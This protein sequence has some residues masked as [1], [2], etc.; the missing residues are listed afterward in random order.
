MKKDISNVVLLDGDVLRQIFGNDADHTIN[1]REK[2]ARR[3][4]NLSKF[5]SNE[6][7]HVVAAVSIFPEWQSGIVITFQDTARY[8]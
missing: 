6:G 5:L 3:L 4:S 7:I 1:G 8:L 2:N